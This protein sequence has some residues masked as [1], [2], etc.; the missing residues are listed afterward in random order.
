MRF[1]LGGNNT[2]F[3]LVKLNTEVLKIQLKNGYSIGET[4]ANIQPHFGLLAALFLLCYGV[5]I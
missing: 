5:A 2:L 1:F 3:F 4:V